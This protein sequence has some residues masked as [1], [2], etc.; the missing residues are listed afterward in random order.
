MAGSKLWTTDT[1]AMIVQTEVFPYAFISTSLDK[2]MVQVVQLC[3]VRLILPWS[4]TCWCFNIHSHNMDRQ[5]ICFDFN[6]ECWFKA[7]KDEVFLHRTSI[8]VWRR[9]CHVFDEGCDRH[10]RFLWYS[11]WGSFSKT[12][13]L[14]SPLELITC[15]ISY[16]NVPNVCLEFFQACF[17][18]WAGSMSWRR[19]CEPLT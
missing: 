10:W 2:F 4:K 19:G 12:L 1:C 11:H 17:S 14:L 15:D 7:H 13:I 18:L 5:F 16:D 8:C 6:N 9:P 3:A